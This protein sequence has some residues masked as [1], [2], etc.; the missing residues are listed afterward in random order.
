MSGGPHMAT[1]YHLAAKEL[2]G[3]LSTYAKRFGLLELPLG[4]PSAP[5]LTTLRRYRKEV[6]PSFEFSLILPPALA[7]PRPGP[8][9]DEA[10]AS[11]QAAINALG[12]R[13]V[14]L[15]TSLEVT[16][17]TLWRERVGNLLE[18][19]QRDVTT[20]A[21]EAAGLWEAE[22]VHAQ[23]ARWKVVPVVD[24]LHQPIPKGPMAY[25]RMRALGEVRSFGPTVLERVAEAIGDRRDAYIVFETPKAL[26]EAKTLRRIVA[27]RGRTLSAEADARVVR[28]KVVSP[29]IRV[30]D[31]EQ[32]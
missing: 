7:T 31:D 20:V 8:E 32:E 17:S 16:P 15:R 21:W 26:E 23:A 4:G 14:V 9:L 27:A 22:D 29:K 18:R 10:L 13:C 3:A 5:S 30:P 28:P 1:R 11:S 25:L 2:R 6:A 19:L 24:P 12:A